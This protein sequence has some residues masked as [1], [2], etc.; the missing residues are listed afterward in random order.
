MKDLRLVFNNVDGEE[1]DITLPMEKWIADWWFDCNYVPEN[2][3]E[4][5]IAEL[6]GENIFTNTSITHREFRED[7]AYR[8][9]WD[10]LYDDYMG[11]V[12]I[13]KVKD[14]RDAFEFWLIKNVDEEKLYSI[15]VDK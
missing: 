8:Y 10:E 7:I 15:C 2:D 9:K 1:C 4:I 14:R 3:A 12:E 5:Y 13:G 11:D 6:D